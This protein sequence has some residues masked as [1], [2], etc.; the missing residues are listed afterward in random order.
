[1]Q[2][3]LH[4]KK[5]SL[6]HLQHILIISALCC[7]QSAS[8]NTS[9]K[10]PNILWI[11]SDD[12]AQS[13]ISA[14][15]GPLTTIAPTPNIDRLANE[16]LLFRQSYVATSICIPARATILSGQHG[17]RNGVR[18]NDPAAYDWNQPNV[19]KSLSAAGYRTALFGKIHIRGNPQ[20]FEEWQVLPGQGR[21]YNPVFYHAATE[22]NSARDS[23]SLLS[24]KEQSYVDPTA[25]VSQYPGHV[26]EHIGTMTLDSLKRAADDERPFFIMCHFKA[27]HGSFQPPEKHW[28]TFAGKHIPEPETLFDNFESRSAAPKF[29]TST[30][31]RLSNRNLK[32][33][34]SPQLSPEQLER[35]R[36]AYAD[37]V[38]AY[39][40]VHAS[41]GSKEDIRRRYQRY[42]RDYLACVRGIDDQVGRILK[43]LDESGLA[44]NTIVFYSSDQGFFLG[45]HG[46][47]DK[48][49]MYDETF[50]T[51]LLVRWPEGIKSPGRE[52][53][54]LVQNIDMAPTMLDLAK[55]EIPQTMQGRSITTFL[56]DKTPSN[57]RDAL[58]Y[59][60]YD[61][62]RA[63]SIFRHEGVYDGRFKLIHFYDVDQWELYDLAEDPHETNNL[64]DLAHPAE[65][66]LRSKLTEL[67]SEYAVPALAPALNSREIETYRKAGFSIKDQ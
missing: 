19:A 46:F 16:G 65:S 66:R 37:E 33:E 29:A 41:P 48:R 3:L 43:Y 14:Y 49:F 32:L 2:K 61:V 27:P 42:L 56:A 50:S 28:K 11:Y 57:W 35:W 44:E 9:N 1:M 47:F 54:E 23:Q 36:V 58:Y 10:R 31:S 15:G 17:H 18:G 62:G 6:Q 12:H 34:P 24:D 63:Y 22:A 38:K 67:K 26:S 8:A 64:A 53:K 4:L 30:I 21:Y 55:L 40:E 7:C 39:N 20:G 5:R 51:P 59:A 60:Y 45:E 13:A 25:A 52:V